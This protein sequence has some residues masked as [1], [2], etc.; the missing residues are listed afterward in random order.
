MCY[1]F[2]GKA[3]FSASRLIFIY[4][5]TFFCNL[6][7]DYDKAHGLH[8]QKATAPGGSR[9]DD[10]NMCKILKICVI[11]KIAIPSK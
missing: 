4:Y 1:P 7:G 5:I 3:S 9:K 2:G 6:Q 11:E 10:I 8:T